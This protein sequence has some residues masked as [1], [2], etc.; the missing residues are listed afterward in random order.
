MA[1]SPFSLSFTPELVDQVRSWPLVPSRVT[2]RP[3][4]PDEQGELA[5]LIDGVK[6]EVEKYLG[7]I[8]SEATR[9]PDA[10]RRFM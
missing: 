6:A 5:S 2:E 1:T 8:P 3:L 4:I 10:E 7:P 9:I